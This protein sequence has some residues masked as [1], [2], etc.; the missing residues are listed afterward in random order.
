V[1][2]LV[3]DDHPLV[4]AGLC[5]VL[6][7]L[8]QGESTEVLQAADCRGAFEIARANPDLDLLLLDYH[9]P[10]M[11]GLQALDYFETCHPEL[12]VVILSGSANPGI[13]RRAMAKGAAGFITKSGLSDELLTALREVLDGNIYTSR[14]FSAGDTSESAVGSPPIFTPRQEQVL[15]LL[16]DGCSN[17][18]IG[19]ELE[20]SDETVKSHVSG[21]LRG[22]GVKTRMQAAVEAGRWGYG[23]PLTS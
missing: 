16:L 9:L 15:S 11:N 21:I 4:R 1:K 23:R 10:D 5:Q 2:I 7:G 3:V 6:Q 17:R 20:L 18:E 19:E 14:S 22:F 8:V 12:P 13:M